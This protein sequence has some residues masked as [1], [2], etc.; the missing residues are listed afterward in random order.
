M[1]AKKD[2]KTGKWLIQFRYTDWQGNRKKST[3]RGFNTKREAEE[4]LRNFLLMKQADF[5][6][7]FE[8]F[9]KLYYADME[10]RLREHTMRTKKY[11]I[12]L[13]ILPYFGNKSINEIKPADIRKWQNTLIKQGYSAT[14][15]KTINNQLNAVFNYAVKYY[16]L[17]SNPCSKAGSMGKSNAE[18]MQFWT[19]QEFMQFID[20][21]MNKRQSYMAFMTLYWTGMRIGELLALTLNDIDFERRVISVSKSYQ[22]IDGRDIITPPKTPKSKRVI[23]IPE[24]LVVDL[25]DY[26]G[27]IYGI[28]GTDRI[29]PVTKYFMEHEMQ[30]GIKESGV[31]RI[32][33]HDLRH[34]HASL[35][36][37]MGF[38]PLAIAE[39]LGHER[40][41]TTMNTYAHLYPNKQV[42]I[43]DKLETE[44]KEGLE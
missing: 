43:A 22:R 18:E 6:M 8:D 30:R 21:V 26:I 15:L 13:K 1:K 2:P 10:T 4:W 31:K 37:E 33:L 29:F 17:K 44:Y 38:S 24:F 5:D 36:I 19:K 27:S 41:E 28:D 32:R 34:S 12:D 20:S 23:N 42:Q 25:K 14:Y 7:H 40:V 39:R 35:L 9:L 11:I 16:D 3:K